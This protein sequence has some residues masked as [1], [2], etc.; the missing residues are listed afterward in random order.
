VSPVEGAAT[1]VAEP[2][3]NDSVT[4]CESLRGHAPSPSLLGRALVARV[5][6]CVSRFLVIA[7]AVAA[8]WVVVAER[9]PP[10]VAAVGLKLPS[11]AAA[12]LKL[13]D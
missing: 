11:V 9:E 2:Y 6:A 13:S 12:G 3:Q 8:I 7:L 5:C 1:P 10:W 4:L